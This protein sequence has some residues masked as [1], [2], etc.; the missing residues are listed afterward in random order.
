MIGMQEPEIFEQPVRSV[1]K[2][3]E[4]A[5]HEE[6]TYVTPLTYTTAGGALQTVTTEDSSTSEDFHLFVYPEGMHGP[7]SIHLSRRFPLIVPHCISFGGIR[8]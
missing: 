6:Q 4:A 3:P 2:D 5:V 8:L 1:N 7:V